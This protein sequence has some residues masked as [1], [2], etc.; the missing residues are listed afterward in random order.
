MT[1]TQQARLDTRLPLSEAVPILCHHQIDDELAFQI[2]IDPRCVVA[3][4]GQAADP[5]A[6]G[7]IDNTTNHNLSLLRLMLEFLKPGS[8]M[9]DLGAHLGTFALTAAA[10]G[11]RALAVEASPLNAA[12]LLQ[13]VY[14][15]HWS[16]R[17]SVHHAAIG[18]RTGTVSFSSHG[19]WGHVANAKTNLPSS[20]V[21]LIELD[22]LLVDERVDHLDFIKLDVEGSEIEALEGGRRFLRRSDA[23]PI[24]YESNYLGLDYYDRTPRELRRAFTRLGYRYHYLISGS[25]LIAVDPREIQPQVV[26]EYL[27]VKKPLQALAGWFIEEG[28]PLNQMVEFLC[29]NASIESRY[30]EQIGKA[31]REAPRAVLADPEIQDL[32]A[33]CWHDENQLVHASVQW[34]F[35]LW[36]N[37]RRR[38]NR[39]LRR[40]W[41]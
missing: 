37:V 39:L 9:L 15:N 6:M 21:P 30:K 3:Q 13:S 22:R 2:A 25:R 32:L 26:G 33:A 11:C 41:L 23:P 18:N 16:K 31:L 1:Q 28:L 17:L 40:R 27:A 20:K 36:G 10:R 14:A 24:L 34:N 35:G 5:I 4:P 29:H 8:A 12:L 38:V 7:Y 19:P